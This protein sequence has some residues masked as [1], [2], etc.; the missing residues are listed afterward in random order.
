[1]N[2][3]PGREE[4][5]LN[6]FQFHPQVG[7]DGVPSVWGTCTDF[8]IHCQSYCQASFVCI[9]DLLQMFSTKL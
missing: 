6:P 1:V 8:Q 4:L 5:D 7:L 9:T 2:A 3:F